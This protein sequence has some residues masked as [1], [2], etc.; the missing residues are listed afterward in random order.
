MK[1]YLIPLLLLPLLMCGCKKK[2]DTFAF[3]G[4]VRGYLQCTM[5]TASVSEMDFGYVVSLSEPDSIGKNYNAGDGK[6]YKNCV[7]LY[8]TRTRCHDGD[9][10]S[11]TMYLDDKYSKAYCNYHYSLDLPEGVCYTID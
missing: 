11:G 1:K 7:I 10:I 5:A 8:R 2:V 3:S 6:T 4:T 9:K